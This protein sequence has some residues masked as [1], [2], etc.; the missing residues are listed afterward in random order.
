MLRKEP[1]FCVSGAVRSIP[2]QEFRAMIDEGL[3]NWTITSEPPAPTEDLGLVTI[4][5]LRERF[6][7]RR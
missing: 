2:T 1:L 4:L 5:L 6:P 3:N 7:C